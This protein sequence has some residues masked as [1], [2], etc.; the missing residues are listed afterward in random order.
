MPD[1]PMFLNIVRMMQAS[2][3]SGETKPIDPDF[4]SSSLMRL[5]SG[6]LQV[7][8]CFS[9][10]FDVG[11]PAVQER[12]VVGYFLGYKGQSFVCERRMYARMQS[13]TAKYGDRAIFFA[14]LPGPFDIA[15]L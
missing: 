15:G 11:H 7:A 8:F 3:D 1:S 4:A 14:G 2:I 10:G 13:M 6:V 9:H 12:S 5:T